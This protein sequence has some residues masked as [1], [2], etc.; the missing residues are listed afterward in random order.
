MLQGAVQAAIKRTE[1]GT[2]VHGSLENV[3]IV[4][5]PEAA[6]TFLLDKSHTILVCS[7]NQSKKPYTDEKQA[8]ETFTVLDGGGGTVD[9]S[10]YT[11]TNTYQLRLNS[12]VGQHSGQSRKILMSCSINTDVTA[13]DNCGASH[14]NDAFEQILLKR[15]EDEHYL[16]CN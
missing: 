10:T 1:F 14:L 8:G 11:V 15:L 9:G 4:S 7:M 16:D 6:A 13:G 2:L 5:E 12:E 3:F